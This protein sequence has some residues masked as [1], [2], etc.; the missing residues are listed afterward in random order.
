MH[1]YFFLASYM[2]IITK[3]YQTNLSKTYKI[4][5][6]VK[7]SF[8]FNSSSNSLQ[9]YFFLNGQVLRYSGLLFGFEPWN[10]SVFTLTFFTRYGSLVFS[11]FY[12]FYFKS[13]KWDNSGSFLALSSNHFFYFWIT[14]SKA[15]FSFLVLVCGKI[16]LLVHFILASLTGIIFLAIF[17]E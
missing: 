11:S 1:A 4:K 3:I 9:V 7:Y 12:Y 2:Y 6:L 14:F 16:S 10:F 15:T 13:F 8:R 5:Y 17:Y